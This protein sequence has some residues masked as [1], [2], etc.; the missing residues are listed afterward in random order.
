MVINNNIVKSFVESNS[1][2]VIKKQ[3]SNKNIFILKYKNNV[4][5]NDLW[6]P[7]LEVCRGTLIDNDYN[8]IS[9]PF[10]KIYNFGIEKR[11]PKITDETIVT[12]FRKIN[13]FMA[14]LTWHDDLIISTTGSINSDFVGYVKEFITDKYIDLC[15]KNKDYTFMF[16]C[17][18]ANDPHIIEEKP[19][20]YYLGKRKKDWNSNIEINDIEYIGNSVGCFVPEKLI[21]PLAEL[22]ILL[23]SVKHEGFVIYTND[24]CTKI[25]SPYYLINKWLA[26]SS[27]KKLSLLLDKSKIDEEYY[28][29]IDYI[30]ENIN[31]FSVLDE[32]DK[33]KF[34][35]EFLG[36]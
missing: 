31:S 30:K 15:K 27:N 5:F 11:A 1:K 14:A 9:I 17:V 21:I 6:N 4:F 16:E 2:L 34:I 8:I 26:R 23:K 18:H 33:L 35:K 13:G 12:A 32:Q 29:L 20:L 10:T 36:G 7:I 28:P 3:S 25:K 19:G 24:I 22:K